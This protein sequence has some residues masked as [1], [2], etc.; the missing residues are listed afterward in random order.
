M[1]LKQHTGA[2]IAEW[3]VD[4]VGVSSDPANV[5]HTGKYVPRAVVKYI[6]EGGW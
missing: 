6:L 1:A 2:T 5:R 3:A 4:Y